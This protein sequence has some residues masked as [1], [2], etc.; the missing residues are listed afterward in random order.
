LKQTPISFC[1]Y[2]QLY[3]QNLEEP[4]QNSEGLFEYKDR[5]LSTTW[6]ISVKQVHSHDQET[7]GLLRLL[8]YFNNQDIWYELL[9][10]GRDCGL[11]W[12]FE[13]VKTEM[14]FRRA[15]TK[16]CDYSLVDVQP[17]SYSIHSCVHDWAPGFLNHDLNDDLY[18]AAV[19]C[20]AQNVRME[21]ELDW[22]VIY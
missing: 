14:R 10:P 20:V 3:D 8:A 22:G 15:M 9:R 4:E 17:A 1:Q 11:S 5:R 6:S 13:V 18:G 16:L 21:E 19:H 2:L 7:V 12:L